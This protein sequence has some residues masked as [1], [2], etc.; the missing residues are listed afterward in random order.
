M[1]SESEGIEDFLMLAIPCLQI[2]LAHN[3]RLGLLTHGMSLQKPGK[4]NISAESRSHHVPANMEEF[5]ICQCER[6]VYHHHHSI[7]FKLSL[8]FR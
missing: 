3:A 4:Q 5:C 2:I 6:A 7:T 8:F 1:F